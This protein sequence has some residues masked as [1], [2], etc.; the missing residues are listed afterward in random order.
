MV[1]PTVRGM[2]RRVAFL[3]VL[4][5][6]ACAPATDD[7]SDSVGP[8]HS[9]PQLLASGEA[10]KLGAG[11][12]QL[13]NAPARN[14]RTIA[15]LMFDIGGGAPNETMI[16]NLLKGETGSLQAMYRE[17]SYGMQDLEIDVLGPYELDEQTCLPIECCGPKTNQP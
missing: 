17:I 4:A 6:S 12:A 13:V 7:A 2:S 10:Q 14:A 9:E 16:T 8:T 15:A 1:A 11:V 5:L 3:G